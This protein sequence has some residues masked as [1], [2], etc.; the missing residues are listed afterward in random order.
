MGVCVV[1]AVDVDLFEVAPCYYSCIL[2][3][4]RPGHVH[5]KDVFYLDPFDELHGKDIC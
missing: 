3:F 2:G 5:V 4:F 1:E